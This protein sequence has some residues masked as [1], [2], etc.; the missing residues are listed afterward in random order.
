MSHSDKD[1][2]LCACSVAQNILAGDSYGGEM[3][4]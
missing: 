4:P 1:A 3:T 2:A